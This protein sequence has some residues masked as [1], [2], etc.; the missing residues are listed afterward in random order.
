M[1][2]YVIGDLQG[3]AHEAQALLDKI[4]E[5]AAGDARILFVGDLINRGPESLMALRRMKALSE[6]SG[7][8]VEALLGNHDLHLLAVAVGAQ[9]ASKSDTLDEILAAPDLDELVA[10]L[11]ARPLAMFVD[12]H[13]LVHA[14]VAPQWD[15]AKT[16]A[17]AGEVEAV[18]RGDGWIDF[19]GQMY[20]NQ[21]DR[22]DDSL[23]GVDRLRC[24]VNALTR[25]RLC[26]PDGSMDFAHKESE[27]GPEG[28]GL[29]PWFDLPGRKTCDVT[30]VFGHWSALGLVLRPNLVGLDSGC[31]WGGKLTAVCLDDRTL[32]QVDCP[33][34]RP[35]SGKK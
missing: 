21:P 13:L 32:L 9:K 25:M 30:V 14:G 7:G 6:A 18:L 2:T 28:S 35:H 5:D 3:C 24:I 15:A 34:Y 33:E 22:W 16:M 27:S 20:G 10:W 1:K 17:L 11:R 23:E 8:R 12:A 31:V 4:A 26:L 29:V 19:L